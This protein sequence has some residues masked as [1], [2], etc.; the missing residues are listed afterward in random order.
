MTHNTRKK[1]RESAIVVEG[2]NVESCSQTSRKTLIQ[3][4]RT[5]T[6][7]PLALTDIRLVAVG[8]SDDNAAPE[9]AYGGLQPVSD[10]V[11]QV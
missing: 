4:Y 6:E 2:I 3:R 5:S 1:N 11:P 10:V 8:R 9:K 7:S